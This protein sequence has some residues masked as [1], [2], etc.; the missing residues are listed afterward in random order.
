[1]ATKTLPPITPDPANSPFIIDCPFQGQGQNEWKVLVRNL[2]PYAIQGAVGVYNYWLG[3]YEQDYWEL[4]SIQSFMLIPV[5]LSTVPGGSQ[6]GSILITAFDQS[7]DYDGNFP[8]ALTP[9][10]LEQTFSLIAEGELT[11]DGTSYDGQQ[12]SGLMPQ[13]FDAV[14]AMVQITANDGE[15]PSEN[16]IMVQL[17][18]LDAPFTG[19]GPPPGLYTMDAKGRFTFGNAVLSTAAPLGYWELSV[20]SPPEFP[21]AKGTSMAYLMKYAIYGVT[22]AEA[23]ALMAV[24][25]TAGV[26]QVG[27]T[28]N[29]GAFLEPPLRS[30]RG[31]QLVIDYSYTKNLTLTLVR[32]DDMSLLFNSNHLAVTTSVLVDDRSNGAGKSRLARR[33]VSCCMG[34]ALREPREPLRRS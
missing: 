29:Q 20:A 9:P 32:S 1:M 31:N 27:L 16:P 24:P 26:S 17:L 2:S 11:L 6:L 33:P 25:P 3:P 4:N 14:I 13:P 21:L 19:D 12:V 23:D 5:T 28:T 22:I 30:R 8:V 18:C 7:S 10:T 34:V 15:E